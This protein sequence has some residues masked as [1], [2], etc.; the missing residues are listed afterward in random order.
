MK[1]FQRTFLVLALA[2]VMCFGATACGDPA[3]ET[4]KGVTSTTITVGNTA[5]T[6]GALAAVGDPFNIGL[7]AAF[8][9]YNKAGGYTGKLADGTTPEAGLQVALKH[10]SDESIAANSKALTEKLI[11]EDE[12]FAIVGNFGTESIN[13]NVPVIKEARVPMVYAAGG[14]DILFNEKATG[15]DR[16]IF[17]VQ[18]VYAKEGAML[19]LRAISPDT[20]NVLGYY[21]YVNGG[22]AGTKIGVIADATDASKTLVAGVEAEAKAQGVEIKK[23]TV[24]NE[25]YGTVATTI[26]AD[27]C[28]V[29]IITSIADNFVN[30]VTALAQND[31]AV[32]IITTYTNGASLFNGAD[33]QTYKTAEYATVLTKLP[34]IYNQGWVDIT[35]TY[36]YKDMTK[37][38]YQVY[39]LLNSN[40]EAPLPTMNANNEVFGFNEEYWGVAEAIFD[41][42]MT[43]P[44]AETAGAMA[45]MVGLGYTANSYALAG[46]IAGDLFCKGLIALENSGKT[47]TRA[48]YVD[49]MEIA[50]MDLALADKVSYMNGSRTGV[51]EL[52]LLNIANLG[53][54]ATSVSVHGLKGADFYRDLLNQ[55]A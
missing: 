34:F 28:D 5:A 11:H 50:E 8:Y 44:A 39:A 49:A 46:Y 37:P 9:A 36:L 19:L 22:L 52:T 35:G 27:Q 30:A 3:V 43:T 45:S 1:K 13:A 2:F 12:V 29:V 41:Y 26:K 20:A 4:L 31:C 42:Y 15:E 38:L 54:G 10:Y 14:N 48:N 16:Y 55:N 33:G 47:L 23:Y 7:Q 6:A 21:G 40:P 18:P 24:S 51:Q 17:P 32:R 25:N 53:T